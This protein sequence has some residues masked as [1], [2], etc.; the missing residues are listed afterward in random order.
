MLVLG[1]VYSATAAR[2]VTFWDAGEFLAAFH[3]LGIPHPPGTPL[4]VLAGTVVTRWLAVLGTVLPASLLSAACTASAAAI[5]AS[6]VTRWTGRVAF[7]VAAA[8]CAG[9][10]SSVWL[11]ATE[12]EVYAS[13]L[14]LAMLCVAVA[15]RIA[16]RDGDGRRTTLLAYLLGLAPPLHLSALVA[17]PTAAYLASMRGDGSVKWPRAA[18]LIG[19]AVVAAGV[20]VARPSVIVVGVLLALGSAA[21]VDRRTLLRC[22]AELL[23]VALASSALLVLLVRARHEPLLDQGA[24]ATWRA[25]V[26]VI[27]RR[28]YAVAAPWPRQAPWWLQIAN[29]GE[30][31]D[32]Q[33][34]L[35]LDAGVGPRALRTPFTALY[36]VLGAFGA[37]ALRRIDT[38]AWRA[39]ASLLLAGSL[40]VV[41]YLNLHAG[42]SFGA[43]VLPEGALHEARERDYFFVLAFWTW[44]LFAG[45]GAVVIAERLVR[46]TSAGL[47][48]AALP[49]ALNWNAATRVAWPDAAMPAT[50]AH[51]LLDAAPR[52]AV[53]L[54]A[55]DNDSYPVW[56]AQLA[57][58]RRSD[59]T[60]ITIPLLGAPWYRDEMARRHALLPANARTRWMGQG[61]TVRAIVDAAAARGRAVVVAA[62]V[63]DSVR[64]AL[65]GG[66][67]LSGIVWIRDAG[68]SSH[69]VVDTLRTARVAAR[70]QAIVARPPR[71]STDGAG[72]WGAALLACPVRAIAAVRAVPGASLDGI[73]NSK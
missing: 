1:V 29:V 57:E 73:C 15:D 17:A 22:V 35:G 21:T 50:I 7:G 52:N 47:A 66:W 37:V 2:A 53:L 69:D 32:W 42:P 41:A 27:A 4:F 64:H 20:G 58:H 26:D 25:F 59:V 11:N 67:R 24:P 49:I 33:F 71:V 68:P 28:Q 31:A 70:V 36:L 34:A 23:V 46:R 19:L 63:P 55:G 61:A 12:A 13:S 45:I 40:G 51:E 43:G 48:L 16:A 39:L 6:L 30:W 3:T 65:G 62:S 54:L 72:E 38:R 14:L 10:T 9:S 5:A 60:P 56:F 18:R 8:I 44:G